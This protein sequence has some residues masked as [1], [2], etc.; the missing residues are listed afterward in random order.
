MQICSKV[1]RQRTQKLDPLLGD[2]KS[3]EGQNKLHADA[4]L[5]HK[6]SQLRKELRL[7]LIE[8]YDKHLISLKL[9]HYSSGNQ[10]GQFLAQKLRQ[11]KSQAKIPY[12]IHPIDKSKIVKPKHI[13]DSVAEYYYSLYNLKEDPFTP[14]PTDDVIL[15]FL[16]GLNPPSLVQM[17]LTAL[18][19]PIT[20]FKL[21]KA[22][23]SL[24]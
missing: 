20:K 16:I 10:A 21:E 13:A 7:T 19:T 3:L 14:Q 23:K 6:L 18:N 9:S 8:Q 12:L 17:Q 1:K 2:I 4:N 24:D 5:A 22:M 15:T 11:H